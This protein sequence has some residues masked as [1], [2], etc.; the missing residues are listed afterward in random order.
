MA[1]FLT[2]EQD[3]GQAHNHRDLNLQALRHAGAYQNNGGVKLKHQPGEITPLQ[4]TLKW[5]A[6]GLA[7]LL[8]RHTPRK[9][10]G[11]L[12]QSTNLLKLR[13]AIA[14]SQ[15]PCIFRQRCSIT[16]RFLLQHFS[17]PTQ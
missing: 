6:L 3:F 9:A 11:K 15:R 7:T 13:F 5:V 14:F 4:L 2:H 10:L 17:A 1:R 12:S 16:H 8:I